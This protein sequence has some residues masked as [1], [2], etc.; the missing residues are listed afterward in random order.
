MLLGSVDRFVASVRAKLSKAKTVVYRRPLDEVRRLSRWGPRAYFRIGAWMR[1]MEDAAKKLP[2]L[3]SPTSQTN[4]LTLWF[5]TGKRFWFQTA[6]CAWTFARHYGGL[7][8]LNLVDDGTLGTEHEREL[9]RLFPD[10]R[11]IVAIR[12]GNESRISFQ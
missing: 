6:F 12:Y 9:R 2:A 1:E 7:I 11:P 10:V 5:L 4:P 3:P 8:V